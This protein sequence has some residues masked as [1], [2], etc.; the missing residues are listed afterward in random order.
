VRDA[1]SFADA[2]ARGRRSVE[3]FRVYIKLNLSLMDTSLVA[4]K[5]GNRRESWR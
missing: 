1:R 4:A 5:G 3:V 2:A